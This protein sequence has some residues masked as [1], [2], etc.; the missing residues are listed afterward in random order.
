MNNERERHDGWGRRS[1]KR[2]HAA[3]LRLLRGED[4]ETLLC[5]LG[6]TGATLSGWRHH[7]L[8]GGAANL[9]AREANVGGEE[10]LRRKSL[11]ANLSTG[12]ELLR[13][14]IYGMQAGR[15]SFWRKPKR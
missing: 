12:N 15:P 9:K 8:E 2:K 10:T 4:L 13:E 7:F 11:I 6:L 3:V 5:K 1:A 14:K